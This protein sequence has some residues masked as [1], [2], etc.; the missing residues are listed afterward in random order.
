MSKYRLSR[1]SIPRLLSSV[2][3]ALSERL[4]KPSPA[5]A[6][7]R[8]AE[9]VRAAGAERPAPVGFAGGAANIAAPPNAV[10]T[11]TVM[12]HFRA[13]RDWALCVIGIRLVMAYAFG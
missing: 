10:A 9:A 4:S 2:I 7:G 5:G 13:N 6:A 12:A 3:S 1:L 8:A 11:A